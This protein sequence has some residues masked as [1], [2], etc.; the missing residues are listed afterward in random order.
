MIFRAAKVEDVPQVQTLVASIC[1]VHRKWDP[2]RFGFKDNPERIYHH[3]LIDRL[4]D[5]RSPFFV[6]EREG[7]IVAYIVGSVEH[8]IPIYVLSE[9]GWIHDLWVEEEYRNE[10]IARQLVMLS[11]ELFK[12]NGVPQVR[13]QTAQANDVGRKLFESCGFRV[14]V[15]E[16][17]LELE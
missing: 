13:L 16:M 3:W 5:P 17:Q 11:V 9:V 12:Q 2:T 8:E 1:A 4:H 14:S 7:R 10:G 6:A 15:Q